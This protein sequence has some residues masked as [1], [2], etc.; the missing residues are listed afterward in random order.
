MGCRKASTTLLLQ[1]AAPAAISLL[2]LT[3]HFSWPEPRRACLP[4][5]ACSLG[6]GHLQHAL[7]WARAQPLVLR[8]CCPSCP[9]SGARHR[10]RRPVCKTGV[11]PS[12][13][14]TPRC[15]RAGA[16]PGYAG[17]IHRGCGGEWGCSCQGGSE[18]GSEARSADARLS[19]AA[20]A[21]SL[22]KCGR[23]V[24]ITTGGRP[25]AGIC[26]CGGSTTYRFWTASAF[27]A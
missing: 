3:T 4:C 21:H 10:T 2:G 18:L 20:D 24:P 9:T 23:S 13:S 11:H 19:R 12:G 15:L 16:L 8:A 17:H 14:T 25:T 6:D 5:N 22:H 1:A 26:M 7:P 27:V